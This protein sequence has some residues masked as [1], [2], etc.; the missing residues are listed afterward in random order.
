MPG[1]IE[2]NIGRAGHALGC[3]D[4]AYITVRQMVHKDG[5][6]LARLRSAKE[7]SRP[8]TLRLSD[9][10]NLNAFPGFGLVVPVTLQPDARRRPRQR[11]ALPQPRA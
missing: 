10:T 5:A 2:I 1:N 8:I 9:D 6:M 3:G 7:N 11:P 4:Q